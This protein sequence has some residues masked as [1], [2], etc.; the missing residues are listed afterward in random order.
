[1]DPRKTTPSG[2]VFA[3]SVL[4]AGKL[5]AF[6]SS[7]QEMHKINRPIAPPLRRVV[8]TEGFNEGIGPEFLQ[9]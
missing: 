3:P 9:S 5:K 8:N 7:A 2:V 6:L 4:T 1:M